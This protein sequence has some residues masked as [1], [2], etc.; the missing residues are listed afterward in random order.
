MRSIRRI[1]V[2]VKEPGA[3]ALPAVAKAAQLAGALGARLEL[4]HGV[5]TPVYSDALGVAARSFAEIERRRRA[6]DLARLEAVAARLRKDGLK[7]S[8][9]VECDYPAPEAIVRRAR[10]FAADLIVAERHAGRHVAPWLLGFTDWELLRLSPV[11]FLLVKSPRAYRKPV[12]L[13]AV[14]PAHAF[15][16]PA[17]L[18]GEILA[19]GAQ[20]TAALA[21]TLHAVHAFTPAPIGAVPA[22]LSDP[23]LTARIVADAA[24]QARAGFDRALRGARIPAARRHLV[25]GHP[26]NAIRD[27]ARDTGSAIVVM[28]AISRSGLKRLFIGNTAERVLDHLTCDVLVVKPPHFVPRVPR[29]RRGLR[30]ITVPLPPF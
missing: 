15:S 29:A 18:D 30:V 26:I 20:I 28:G 22:E 17:K 16:K 24:A 14:D 13:M 7:V 3:R 19:A 25:V 5:D 10:A 6:A 8:T 21:G 11:P 1:L 27:V 23:N 4:F 9:C 2:A 12:V